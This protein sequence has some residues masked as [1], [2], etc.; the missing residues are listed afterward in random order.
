MTT[1]IKENKIEEHRFLV[2]EQDPVL[3]S[4]I[5]SKIQKENVLVDAAWSAEFARKMLRE[6]KYAGVILDIALP[7]QSGILLIK[8]LRSNKETRDLPIIVISATVILPG[9]NLIAGVFH[10]IDWLDK[11][12]DSSQFSNA[13][14]LIIEAS[15]NEKPTLLYVGDDQSALQ[16]LS[17]HLEGSVNIKSAS[18]FDE[19]EMILN[20]E[21]VDLLI[22][23]LDLP[24]GLAV[25]LLNL[26]NQPGEKCTPVIIMAQHEIDTTLIRDM[27][28]PLLK[29][30]TQNDLLTHTVRKV[31]SLKKKK[32]NEDIKPNG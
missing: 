9:N 14:A 32:V 7:N 17:Q 3:S 20:H 10:I 22:L 8:E 28:T 26:L 13:I 31:L 19:A 27:M 5:Q 23:D 25:S 4:L 24:G 15:Q 6:T 1:A 18:V 12:V 11:P 16:R 21:E 29:S 30:Q 2:V